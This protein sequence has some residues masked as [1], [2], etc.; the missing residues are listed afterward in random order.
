MSNYFIKF[1]KDLTSSLWVK[2]P[3]DRQTDRQ[4]ENIT[5]LAETKGKESRHTH[6]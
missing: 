3:T 2:M 5:S 4:T 1:R 6:S